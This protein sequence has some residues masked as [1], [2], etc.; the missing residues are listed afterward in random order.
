MSEEVD[1]VWIRAW[2]ASYYEPQAKKW[3]YGQLKLGTDSLLFVYK[4]EEKSFPKYF[5]DFS[6]IKSINKAMSSVIFPSI[7]V[8]T[9]QDETHWFSSFHDRN[10]IY[11]VISHFFEASLMATN[12][13][14]RPSK[15][16]LS[17]GLFSKKTELGK[18]LLKSVHDSDN[19]LKK[20]AS[21][22]LH[23]G[24]QLI[25]MSSTIQDVQEDLT[26]AERVT[27]GLN[28]WL[29][30]WKMSKNP[31]PGEIIFVKAIDIPD[32]LDVEILY[33]KVLSSRVGPQTCGVCR[34]E[35]S[36]ITVL[37]MK[38]KVIQHFPWS[39]VSRI[40]AVTPWEVMVTR[41]LIGQPD[42]SYGIVS[43]HASSILS[44]I[45]YYVAS[46][47]EYIEPL[48]RQAQEPPSFK[49]VCKP[50][51]KLCHRE[52]IASEEQPE[53]HSKASIS[54]NKE[55]V[56]SDEEI[57]ELA[58]TLG[59]IKSTALGIKIEQDSQLQNIDDLTCS[60]DEL[61]KKYFSTAAFC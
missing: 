60:V 57:E 32:V 27:A 17:S 52:I 10:S 18:A 43:I 61:N 40:R 12:T 23:Q 4:T 50:D 29:G 39:E 37:D 2:D 26:A 7:I 33:T 58:A 24:E 5:L 51:F 31:K 45:N 56:I 35:S 14:N 42:L 8:K 47:V 6:E 48:L 49:K 15:E 3:F 53:N 41:Y 46:K 1:A 25:A 30:R 54:T 21:N 11:S 19:T 9:F 16:P 59:N 55:T 28:S 34:V 20:A 22:L 36:G 38:Q 13:K 44:K